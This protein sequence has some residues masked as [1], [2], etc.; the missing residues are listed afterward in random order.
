MGGEGTLDP[1]KS[2]PTGCKFLEERLYSIGQSPRQTQPGS[3]SVALEKVESIH[4]SVDKPTEINVSINSDHLTLLSLYSVPSTFQILPCDIEL[5][6]D[7]AVPEVRRVRIF[8]DS[9]VHK[10]CV[11]RIS[12]GV[13]VAS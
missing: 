4:E 8:G 6:D 3:K 11:G 9:D 5:S 7:L 12:S 13:I 10:T 1:L 2:A